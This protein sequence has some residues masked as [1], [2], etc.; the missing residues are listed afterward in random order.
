MHR[1]WRARGG[2]KGGRAHRGGL[3]AE[4]R[5][6]GLEQQLARVLAAK[7]GRELDEVLREELAH[8]VGAVLAEFYEARAHGLLD[9]VDVEV[10]ADGGQRLARR[11]AHVGVLVL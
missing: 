10:A 6:H 3:V 8:A 11:A 2:I 7:D 1:V 5:E 4:Q 9:D